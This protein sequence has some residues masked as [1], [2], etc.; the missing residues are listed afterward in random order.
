MIT[1]PALLNLKPG[2]QVLI[3]SWPPSAVLKVVEDVESE[4]RSKY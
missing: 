3:E 4:N 2:D 1:D